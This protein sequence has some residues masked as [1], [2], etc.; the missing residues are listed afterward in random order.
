MAAAAAAK[1]LS[2]FADPSSGVS[3]GSCLEGARSHS[4]GRISA[5]SPKSAPVVMKSPVPV[6][7]FLVLLALPLV[8]SVAADEGLDR[9]RASYQ[10]AVARA[11]QA[12]RENYAK[13]LN[14]VIETRTR[15]SDLEGAVAAHKALGLLTSDPGENEEGGTQ[16]AD[17][18]L[19]RLRSGYEEASGRALK[20][21]RETYLRE[22]NKIL[23]AR[24][25]ASDLPGAL[26][27][28]KRDRI[29]RK[30]DPAERGR[31]HR[32]VLCGSHLG[33][34]V[35]D[36]VHLRGGRRVP[37]RKPGN[38]V[39]A[40][41]SDVGT[42]SSRASKARLRRRVIFALFRRRKVTTETPRTRSRCPC[43]PSEGCRANPK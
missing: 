20:P 3:G 21:L 33:L 5:R 32:N 25:Q 16:V 29:G 43:C 6:L 38:A 4:L 11:M 10:A 40:R 31:S 1:A 35:R 36:R 13:E 8:D 17:E 30:G 18:E 39:K 2:V 7:P 22:L 23:Q 19:D 24:T 27:V 15:R 34:P 14:R 41:G 9:L 26:A 28:K 42:L 12:P 37:S